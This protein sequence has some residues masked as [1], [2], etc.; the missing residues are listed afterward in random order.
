MNILVTGASGYLG[1]A[2]HESL[3]EDGHTV[4]GTYSHNRFDDLAPLDLTHEDQVAELFSQ[5]SPDY[6]VHC[7]GLVDECKT[8]PDLA[9][10]VN[11]GGT[12][13]ITRFAKEH[14]APMVYI[15]SAAVFDG[16]QGS[17]DESSNPFPV[18]AYG[19][20]KAECEEIVSVNSGNLIIRPSFFVGYAPHGMEARGFGKILKALRGNQVID[21]DNE[22]QFTPSSVSHVS[23]IIKWWMK[24]GDERPGFLHVASPEV[25]T[26]YKL[27]QEIARSMGL[28]N[29]QMDRLLT[30]KPL[31]GDSPMNLL[32]VSRL[33][34]LHAPEYSIGE[35]LTAVRNR[36]GKRT[37]SKER[38]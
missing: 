25:T 29:E 14:D 30:V 22:W 17:F 12:S 9:R 20:S 1:S 21:M 10:T 24:Q 35:L 19:R 8:S 26:K 34:K 31:S 13:I 3:L 27:A 7:V 6:V 33:T 37:V 18:S 28:S 2:I 15:S 16:M 32:D 38:L 36:E 5:V 11:Q 4:T 23:Q